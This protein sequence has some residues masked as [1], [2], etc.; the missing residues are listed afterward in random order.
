MSA[1]VVGFKKAAFFLNH[2]DSLCMIHNIKPVSYILSVAVHRKLF[3][4][5][6]IVDDQRNQFFRKLVRT[7]VVAAVL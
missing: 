6:R 5:E 7:I 2:I 1:D 3:A 4:L